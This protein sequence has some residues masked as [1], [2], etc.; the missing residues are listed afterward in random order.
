M[1]LKKSSKVFY[2]ENIETVDQVSKERERVTYKNAKTILN[3]LSNGS[4]K[5]LWYLPDLESVEKIEVVVE[6]TENQRMYF[7]IRSGK[8]SQMSRSK[9]IDFMAMGEIFI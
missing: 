8:K 3:Q 1:K 7:V 6:N 2:M 4:K 9:L 5:S